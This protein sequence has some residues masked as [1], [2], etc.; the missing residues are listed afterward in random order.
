MLAKLSKE[1]VSA[2][3]VKLLVLPE[4]KYL[5]NEPLYLFSNFHTTISIFCDM[6]IC[7]YLLF[8]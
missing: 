8:T 5:A 1:K 6:Y 2:W 4:M 3:I 7:V